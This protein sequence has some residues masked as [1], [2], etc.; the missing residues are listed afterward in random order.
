V[1]N[2]LDQHMIDPKTRAPNLL[3]FMVGIDKEGRVPLTVAALDLSRYH[4]E[5]GDEGV[6]NLLKVL[7]SLEAQHGD[8]FSYFTGDILVMRFNLLKNQADKV[9]LK[10]QVQ[11][12]NRQT[13]LA[14][15]GWTWVEYQDKTPDVEE[16][17]NDIYFR[18]SGQQES[19]SWW[20]K[21]VRK[22][23]SQL[24]VAQEQAFT[25]CISG[26][27]NQRSGKEHLKRLIAQ[28]HRTKQP[29]S[30]L[31]V[32]G[33]SLKI[34]N[35][36]IGYEAGNQMIC[37]LANLLRSKIRSFDHISRWL[38]GD[39][40][41]ILLPKT[42]GGEAY[43]VAERLRK[44]VEKEFEKARYPVTISIGIAC[45]PEN[46][47]DPDQLIDSAQEAND[48]AKRAGKN[49]VQLCRK[50]SVSKKSSTIS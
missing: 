6:N 41:L 14:S 22:I 2:E 19:R 48:M 17:L 8:T 11:L 50:R 3:A 38:L 49:Q 4:T 28:Y 46:G 37:R 45:C 33:D 35:D 21:T 27:P 1:I 7:S 30:L 39:E 5:Y 47:T 16:L 31:F 10:H 24:V 9:L 29:C 23:Y 12:Q 25:D 40:F 42:R 13:T 20:I 43:E 18:L 26:L 15:L 34:Y 32:D 36:L 44:E